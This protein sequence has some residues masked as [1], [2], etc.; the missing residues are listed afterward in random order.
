[1]V[2]ARKK[3]DADFKEAAVE[4][5]RSTRRLIAHVARD[6]GIDERTLGRWVNADRRRREGGGGPLGVE[7]SAELARLRK[8]NAELV[9]ER[10]VLKRGV[11]G[12]KQDAMGRSGASQRPFPGRAVQQ[13]LDDVKWHLIRYDNLRVSLAS[14]G[15]LVLSADALIAAGS[16]VLAAQRVS[17][18]GDI[19]VTAAVDI[20]GVLSILCVGFSVTFAAR[21]VA[22]I[23]PWQS[24]VRESAPRGVF[25]DASDTAATVKSFQ[26]FEFLFN[27]ADEDTVLRYAIINLWK[28]IR[29][30]RSRYARLRISLRFLL[31]ALW[32]FLS[33]V[34]LQFSASELHF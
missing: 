17:Q 8:E 1:M 5:V 31:V 22:N 21:A 24:A 23:R 2:E 32:L 4:L 28:C 33:S 27:D 18:R 14:R 19:A 30:Y 25:F 15:A 12:W 10:D 9:A 11:A 29:G 6:L 20:I 16:T 13:R 34:A 3:F 7:E 26:E